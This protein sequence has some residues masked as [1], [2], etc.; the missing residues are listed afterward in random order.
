MTKYVDRR[1]YGCEP[2]QLW[3]VFGACFHAARINSLL[4]LKEEEVSVS[5][6]F[7]GGTG[8]EGN[9]QVKLRPMEVFLTSDVLSKDLGETV[10]ESKNV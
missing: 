8:A 4:L 2:W 10:R 7:E 6:L 3:E 9:T 1:V 5:R